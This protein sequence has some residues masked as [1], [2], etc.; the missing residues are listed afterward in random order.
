SLSGIGNSPIF[1]GNVEISRRLYR[2]IGSL[3]HVGVKRNVLADAAEGQVS[4]HFHQ[5]AFGTLLHAGDFKRSLWMVL[6]VEKVGRLQ[7]AFQ[8]ALVFPFEVLVRNGRQVN[9]KVAAGDLSVVYGQRAR[10]DVYGAVVLS[11]YFP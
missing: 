11:A 9:Y 7:M 6:H 3:L 1:P 4:G 5:A 8:L 10:L 2:G